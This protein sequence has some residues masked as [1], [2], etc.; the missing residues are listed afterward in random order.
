MEVVPTAIFPTSP[1]TFAALFISTAAVVVFVK[2]EE[3]E[4]ETE[5]ETEEETE[6]EEAGVTVVTVFGGLGV[7]AR[8][9]SE[10]A[11]G[12]VGVGLGAAGAG[13]G[14]GGVGAGDVAGAGVTEKAARNSSALK[15]E[16]GVEDEGRDE[17]RYEEEYEVDEEEYEAEDEAIE[18]EV[19]TLY[20]LVSSL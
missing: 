16:D 10:A 5:E 8:S 13:G 14:V 7:V 9:G 20:L 6:G 19:L 15:E 18:V 4:D 2:S 1:A 12:G 17:G 11:E 3:T